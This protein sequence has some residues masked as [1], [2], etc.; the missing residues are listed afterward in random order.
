MPIDPQLQKNLELLPLIVFIT[1]DEGELTWVS[2]RWYQA[3]GISR[4]ALLGD[5]WAKVV[6]PDDIEQVIFLW[7]R[8]FD[9]GTPFEATPRVRHADGTYHLYFSRAERMQ[10]TLGSTL[11]VGTTIDLSSVSWERLASI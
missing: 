9:A 4:D 5:A 6:H 2:D 11:W 7:T 1:T 10:D 8:A 3:T